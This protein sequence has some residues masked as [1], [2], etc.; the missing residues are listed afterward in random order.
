MKHMFVETGMKI[1]H[2][3]FTELVVI[4]KKKMPFVK[5]QY[6]MISRAYMGHVA[7][8][9]NQLKEK[10][11]KIENNNLRHKLELM[12]ITIENNRLKHELEIEKLKNVKKNK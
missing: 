6:G 4:P 9:I 7:E 5:N 1:K 2:D 12:E 10:D 8:L 11:H 3:K